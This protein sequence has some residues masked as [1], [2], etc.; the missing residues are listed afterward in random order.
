MLSIVNCYFQYQNSSIFVIQQFF[1][2]KIDISIKSS[3][4]NTWIGLTLKEI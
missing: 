2:Y 4:N 1:D 3:K